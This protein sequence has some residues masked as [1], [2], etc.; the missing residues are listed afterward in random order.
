M[1]LFRTSFNSGND[2]DSPDES[3][4]STASQTSSGLVYGLQLSGKKSLMKGKEK[5]QKERS[6]LKGTFEEEVDRVE[7]V[8]TSQLAPKWDQNKELEGKIANVLGK[9]GV[10]CF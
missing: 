2:E 4:A 9:S 10:Y 5:K 7:F 1:R 8:T 6:E 3:A